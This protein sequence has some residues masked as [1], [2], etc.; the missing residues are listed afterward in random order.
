MRPGTPWPAR[1][2][3]LWSLPRGTHLQ[4]QGGRAPRPQLSRR[5][6]PHFT[7][8]N[9]GAFL[10]RMAGAGRVTG[11]HQPILERP[12]RA[13]RAAGAAAGRP[14]Q[15]PWGAPPPPPAAVSRWPRISEAPL[16]G[17]EGKPPFPLSRCPPAALL[18]L[19]TDGAAA[20]PELQ[21]GVSGPRAG[22]A[23][24]PRR[25]GH[26]AR[27]RDRPARR[28][29]SEPGRRAPG[30]RLPRGPRPRVH[31][32]RGRSPPRAPASSARPA[33]RAHPALSEP[34]GAALRPLPRPPTGARTRF[35]GVGRAAPGAGMELRERPPGSRGAER[36]ADAGGARPR[37]AAAS[38]RLRPGPGRDLAGDGRPP[39]GSR[40]IAPAGAAAP[41][42]PLWRRGPAGPP[43]PRGARAGRA[44]GPRGGVGRGSRG[45]RPCARAHAAALASASSFPGADRPGS[46]H[47]RTGDGCGARAR[48]GQGAP[49]RGAG[50]QGAP[51]RGAG[52]TLRSRRSRSSR[53]P[54]GE[55]NAPRW[56]GV[57][58]SPGFQLSRDRQTE[59]SAASGAPR[60]P[61]APAARASRRGAGF[62][63][64]APL[65]A[66]GAVTR[67]PRLSPSRLP[68]PREAGGDQEGNA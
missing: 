40:L 35:S 68:F 17:W 59:N 9:L 43:A 42:G 24:V 63:G 36:A 45:R 41:L 51:R 64:A 62:S 6:F 14:R 56:V 22:G 34:L 1:I 54:A 2:P 7:G 5:P 20:P 33:G 67:R 61:R 31:G 29:S 57:K 48:G 37:L 13:S 38:P 26:R 15:L 50:G 39:A 23:R 28:I 47:W 46:F 30:A 3:A 11:P 65:P 49:R 66:A 8:P 32:A 18:P 55:E 58:A 4:G 52:G 44:P 10:G 21:G 12:G 53:P 60:P 16:P 25:S 27:G 19:E